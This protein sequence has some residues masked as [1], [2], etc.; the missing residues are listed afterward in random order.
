MRRRAQDH[1]R[2]ELDPDSALSTFLARKLEIDTML[3]RLSAFSADHFGIGP[4]E[5]HWGHVGTLGRHAELLR[6]VSDS[7]FREGDCAA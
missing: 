7:A 4:E 3:Q 5:V 1:H 2:Q 6:Q